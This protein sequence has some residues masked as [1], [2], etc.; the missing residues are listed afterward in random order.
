MKLRFFGRL[1]D[2][3]GASEREVDIPAHVS[4]VSDA[5]QWLGDDLP[6]LLEPTV[7]VALDDR[8]ALPND[9][10]GDAREISFLPPVS[11]G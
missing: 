5:R 4:T 6:S 9:E 7:R 3:A 8:L 10:I 11:G 2:Q 1:R